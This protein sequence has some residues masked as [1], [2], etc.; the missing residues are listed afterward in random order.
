[1]GT[2]PR[3]TVTQPIS[4]H[5]NA[6]LHISIMILFHP[7][8]LLLWHDSHEE[9]VSFSSAGSYGRATLHAFSHT[10]PTI[11]FHALSR[12]KCYHNKAAVKLPHSTSNGRFVLSCLSWK[13]VS[14]PITFFSF[15]FLQ[16]TPWAVLSLTLFSTIVVLSFLSSSGEGDLIILW[17]TIN[18]F[19]SLSLF[20]APTFQEGGISFPTQHAYPKH[21]F[22]FLNQGI[23]T[24]A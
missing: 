4:A 15:P 21:P 19:L 7:C 24:T 3:I 5:N 8:H 1:M 6:F 9:L 17:V 10:F 22:S 16:Q 20:L 18:S 13:V 14:S 11:L 2:S 23:T 12:A